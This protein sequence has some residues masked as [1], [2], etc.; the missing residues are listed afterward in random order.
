VKC[1]Y[2]FN[3][4]LEYDHAVQTGRMLESDAVK[5]KEL[6]QGTSK[7]TEVA[8]MLF[9]TGSCIIVGNCSKPVLYFIYEF[10][11]TMLRAEYAEISTG[12]EVPGLIKKKKARKVCISMSSEY[13]RDC[14]EKGSKL[15]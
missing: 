11:K 5:K 7:Y 9:R 4:E 15:I 12:I 1:K 14:I 3:N 13:Y 8:F 2:Y 6:N 10:I